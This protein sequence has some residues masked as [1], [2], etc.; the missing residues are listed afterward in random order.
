M[1]FSL[2]DFNYLFMY[3]AFRVLFIV[4]YLKTVPILERVSYLLN[5]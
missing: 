4:D 2:I 5:F 3:I 1:D